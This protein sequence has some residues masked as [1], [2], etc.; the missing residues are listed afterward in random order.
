MM[1]FTFISNQNSFFV[2]AMKQRSY[3]D[4]TKID[5]RDK[6]KRGQDTKSTRRMPWH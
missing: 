4:I 3:G 6:A 1:I 2:T 5:F